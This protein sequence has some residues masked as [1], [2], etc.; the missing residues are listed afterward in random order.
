MILIGISILSLSFFCIGVVYGTLHPLLT[1]DLLRVVAAIGGITVSAT[2]LIVA[3]L[4]AEE[5]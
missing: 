4:F 2:A 3:A 1:T 5:K